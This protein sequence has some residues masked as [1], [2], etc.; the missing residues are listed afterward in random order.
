MAATRDSEAP[1]KITIEK[2]LTMLTPDE[3]APISD[4]YRPDLSGKCSS[5]HT[6]LCGPWSSADV[7]GEAKPDKIVV[8]V[9]PRPQCGPFGIELDVRYFRSEAMDP[10]GKVDACDT[11]QGRIALSGVRLTILT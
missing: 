11:R 2:N 6:T 4:G 10:S 1:R 7:P 3:I 5:C 8:R 9:N